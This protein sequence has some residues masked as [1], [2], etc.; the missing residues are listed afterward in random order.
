MQEPC[1]SGRLE[2]GHGFRRISP[3]AQ[4]VAAAALTAD[5]AGAAAPDGADRESPGRDP[6]RVRCRG[7]SAAL[8][9][10]EPAL[11]LL[12]Y[13]SVRRMAGGRGRLLYPLEAKVVS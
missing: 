5:I 12:H 6:V 3:A 10:N 1:S 2:V 13:H 9:G 4:R 7:H 11:V 8:G